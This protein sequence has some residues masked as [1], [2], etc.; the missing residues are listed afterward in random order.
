MRFVMVPAV[1]SIRSMLWCIP[2][3]GACCCGIRVQEPSP[4][5]SGAGLPV[6]GISI[7]DGMLD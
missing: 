4:S 6:T 3:H 1:D 2:M 5:N 7:D